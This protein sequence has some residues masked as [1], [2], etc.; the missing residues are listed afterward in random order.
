[1]T[2]R[3]ASLEPEFYPIERALFAGPLFD[4]L[5]F[6]DRAAS[7]G[8]HVTLLLPDEEAENAHTPHT[9]LRPDEGFE[10]NAFDFVLELHSTHLDLKAESLLY[11]EDAL[12]EQ[13]PILT[14]TMAISTGELAKEM[15][16]ADRIIGVSLLP[17]FAEAKFAE[18]MGATENSLKA[19][20][21]KYQ[22]LHEDL[23]LQG[24]QE[25]IRPTDLTKC[26][27]EGWSV[28]LGWGFRPSP[29][30]AGFYRV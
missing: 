21:R 28:L 17:P 2:I 1:M 29:D 11:L 23:R 19:F 6:A 9:I 7:A 30:E 3:Q 5:P 24:G 15:L 25:W 16:I 26:G 4:V 13:V 12:S 20:C 8:H 27:I 14:L 10:P 18:L 22:C